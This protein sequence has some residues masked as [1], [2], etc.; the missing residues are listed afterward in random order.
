MEAVH[1]LIDLLRPDI[2]IAPEEFRHRL[3]DLMTPRA[4]HT[5]HSLD[6]TPHSASLRSALEIWG[7][8]HQEAPLL[9]KIRRDSLQ[10]GGLAHAR[11]TQDTDQPNL[12]TLHVAGYR[13]QRPEH[14]PSPR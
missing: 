2:V 12:T 4:L 14:R 3:P 10:D 13:L 1:Q 8:H 5:E 7:S 6:T 11:L 9:Y